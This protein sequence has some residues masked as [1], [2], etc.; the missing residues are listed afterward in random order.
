MRPAAD[1]F[2]LPP[3][4]L[5]WALGACVL[6]LVLALWQGQRLQ[7]RL[8]ALREQIE[9][10]RGRD[11]LTGL[12]TRTEF[13]AVLNEAA[14]SADRGT[15]PLALM[16]V[17]LD[18]F[19]PLN[20]GYGHRVGDAVL[21]QAG[22]RL[23]RCAGVPL[24]LSRVGGDEFAL[25]LVLGADEASFAAQQILRALQEP[26]RVE[27]LELQL[28]ASVGIALYPD[29]GSRPRL[30]AHAA[31]AMRSVKQVG[32]ASHAFYTPAL[33]VDQREQAELLQALRHAVQ[34]G[35]L[36]LVYQP[37]VDARN[38]QI[39]AAEALL[40]WQ[41]PQ[42]GTISPVVFIP[43]AERHG[44][45]NGIGR[46]VIEEACRQAAQ[47]RQQGMRM[48]V[49][50]NLSGHQLRQDDL[51]PHIQACLKRHKIPAERLTVEIT[52]SVAM[53]DTA[54][55]RA[56]FERLRKAG[57]HVSIDDFGTGHSSLATLRRLPAAELKIDRAFITD[58]GH[59]ERARSIVQAVVQMARTL[60]L[61]VVAEGVETTAQRDVLVGLGCN[62]L[63]GYLFAKP[64][65]A[66]AL[67]LWADTDEP[68]ADG[69]AGPGFRASIF[70]AT[71]PAPL[72]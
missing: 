30:L 12:S 39:T 72:K 32:G 29:H 58:L 6:L 16:Y 36:Q 69:E 66:T 27:A 13:E 51:V 41:H 35:E 45:I 38:L 34:R 65:S 71:A 2:D 8:A 40:R 61:R 1:A 53:D 15:A 52:E 5:A 10:L 17:G 26:F 68:P 60:E 67:A 25:L 9:R 3:E 20:D 11:A 28:S 54:H 57:L 44:L 14:L 7:A 4:L 50:V 63:Q 64:M 55:T 37:K 22:E 47:W 19:R 31:L 49:A 48:R 21:A 33:A 23:G 42:R 56:A 70:E 62:E 18:D 46:W 59:S 24:A 43:L